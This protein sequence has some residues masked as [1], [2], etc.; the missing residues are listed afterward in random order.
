VRSVGESFTRKNGSIFPV[1][2]SSVPLR[3]GSEV[4]GVA[5]VFRDLSGPGA[6]GS[7]I[8]MLL[9]DGRVMVS[10]AF[11]LLLDTQEGLE[12]VGSSATS[13]G[14]VADAARL[15]PDV[16]LVNF[17]LPDLDGIATARLINRVAPDSTVILITESHDEALVEAAVEAGCAG[18]LDKERGWVELVSA[19]RSVFHGQSAFSQTDLKRILPKLAVKRSDALSYLTPREVEVLSYIS[20]GLSNRAIA[21]RLDVT[22]NT[23]RN[24][25]QRILYKLGVHS[26]LEAVVLAQ[27]SKHTE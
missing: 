21:G 2:Y 18:V 13:A 3:I 9:I 20:E 12:V 26:K 16:V 22:A 6:V 11:Q 8:R 19:V 14:G 17:E 1:A 10:D 5:V 4:E 24:H 25:V 15:Q 23:I 7:R 27:A